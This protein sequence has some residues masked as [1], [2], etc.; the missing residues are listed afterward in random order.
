MS[1]DERGQSNVNWGS[2]ERGFLGRL[3]AA[4]LLAVL[5]GAGGS[6]GL[7][8]RACW[9]NDSRILLVLMA[10]WVLSPFMAL[11][12]ASGVSKRWS[13]PTRASLYGVMLV[14]AL[15]SLAI[16]GA[17]ALRPPRP[18][19]A[20]AFIAGP[21]ATWLFMAIAVPIAAVTSGRLSRRDDGAM[22]T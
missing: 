22:R 21:P 2:P 20:F 17:D 1:I 7:M 4:A 11:V 12:W 10:I 18:Q 5:A 9:H 8:L 15:G 3:R 16:Y 13:V 14:V 19:G 6:A